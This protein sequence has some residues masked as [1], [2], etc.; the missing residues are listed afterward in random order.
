[1]TRHDA[2]RP[3]E[4]PVRVEPKRLIYSVKNE[5]DFDPRICIRARGCTYGHRSREQRRCCR[6]WSSVARLHPFY[7]LFWVPKTTAFTE[8]RR[9]LSFIHIIFVSVIGARGRAGVLGGCEGAPPGMVGLTDR[10]RPIRVPRS[11]SAANGTRSSSRRS[12][13]HHCRGRL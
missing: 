7:M 3:I 10:V 9:L 12:H 1:M 8:S 13:L 5:D 6:G 11:R 2:T 4:Q